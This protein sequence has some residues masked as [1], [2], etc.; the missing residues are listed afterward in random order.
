MPAISDPTT[1]SGE[2]NP[3]AA[4][5]ELF[6]P[7]N[8]SNPYPAYRQWRERTPIARLGPR[9]VVISGHAEATQVLHDAAFGHPKPKLAVDIRNGHN[10]PPDE[11]V[12]ATGRVVRAFFSL[13]PPD[14]TRLRRLVSKAFTSRTVE[15]LTSRVEELAEE[16]ITKALNAGE[17]NLIDAIA[18][19]LP[20]AVISELLG[21]PPAD[22]ARFAGWS[23]AMAK[24]TDPDF[25]L[26]PGIRE[27]AARARREFI[28][29]FRVL[30]AERRHAPTAD[31]LSELVL[32]SDAGDTLSEGELLVTLTM[33]LIAGH[34]TTTNLIGNGVLALVSQPE[35]LDALVDDHSLAEYA[36]EEI[37]RYDSPVQLTIR[38]ALRDTTVGEVAVSAG[39]SAVILLGAANRDPAAYPDPDVLDIT[40]EPGR[41]LAFG[42]GI[43][44]CLGAPLAR[45]E[46]RVVLRELARRAPRMTL[47]SEPT[48]NTTVTLRGLTNLPMTLA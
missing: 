45:L 20:I 2:L 47:A 43:H 5:A 21:V 30:A 48:W 12:D 42:H 9:H 36:V 14:H 25:L 40:R 11:P 15:H 13:N 17:V 35:Q 38:T 3:F 39:T 23:H 18:A 24:A 29:Y 27:I 7:T 34:E 31:L 16:M 1:P 26:A 33:L 10:Y 8:R 44:F 6:S 4:M 32:V 46:G 37:L 28:R 19:P 41:H 22:R